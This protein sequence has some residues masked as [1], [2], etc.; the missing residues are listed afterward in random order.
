[1]SIAPNR[2]LAGALAGVLGLGQHACHLVMTRIFQSFDKVFHVPDVRDI[3]HMPGEEKPGTVK[4]ELSPSS[5][6]EGRHLG[7][8]GNH[9]SALRITERSG[10][11]APPSGARSADGARSEDFVNTERAPWCSAERAPKDGARSGSGAHGALRERSA[12]RAPPMNHS[13]FCPGNQQK[14]D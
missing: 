7:R 3:W 2:R 14:S 10:S 4:S 9:R 8:V 13:V 6:G 1:V 12:G 11:G 5:P